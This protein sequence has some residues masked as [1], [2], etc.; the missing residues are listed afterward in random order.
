MLLPLYFYAKNDKIYKNLCKGKIDMKN[1]KG[2]TMVTLVIIIVV[3]LILSGVSI[4]IGSI[5]VTS[6]KDSV[7]NSEAKEVQMAVISQY[8]KYLAVK[9]TGLFFGTKCDENGNVTEAGEYYLLKTK[10][11]EHNLQHQRTPSGLSFHQLADTS[12]YHHIPYL[13]S[14]SKFFVLI[15]RTNFS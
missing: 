10:D 15:N 14:T 9:D 13:F 1:N 6:Y 4:G 5:S 3:L 2:I 7:L 11:L 12:L 8:Q